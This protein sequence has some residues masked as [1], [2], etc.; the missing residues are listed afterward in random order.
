MYYISLLPNTLKNYYDNF[1]MSVEYNTCRLQLLVYTLRKI[2]T[3]F[4]NF[5]PQIL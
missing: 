2:Q 5:I 4:S 1:L 3:I